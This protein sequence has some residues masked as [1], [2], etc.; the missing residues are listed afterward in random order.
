M[1]YMVCRVYGHDGGIRWIDS[2]V[3]FISVGLQQK[4]LRMYRLCISLT[5][6]GSATLQLV[7][8]SLLV[9]LDLPAAP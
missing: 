2:I 9:S 8:S 3:W 1:L 4:A 5:L 7:V 6:K